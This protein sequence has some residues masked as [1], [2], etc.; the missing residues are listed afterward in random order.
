[1]GLAAERAALRDRGGRPRWDRREHGASEAVPKPGD[2]DNQA[3]RGEGVRPGVRLEAAR[4]GKVRRAT[5]R[6]QAE[7][8]I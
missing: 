4:Q 3:Q 5:V 2:C 6:R 8:A 1:M 7:R